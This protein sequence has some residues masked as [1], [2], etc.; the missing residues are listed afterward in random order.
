MTTSANSVVILDF[1]TSGLS[2]DMGDRAIEVGAVRLE[3]GVVKARFQ[4]LMNPGRRIQPFIEQLTGITNAMLQDAPPCKDVMPR[5]ADF[6]GDSNLVA[7]NASFDRR[8]LDAELSYIGRSY[9]GSFACSV[10]A[11]RRIY[12]DA[13]SH[14]LG[15][16]LKYLE[17]PTGEGFHR[18]LYDAE[19]TAKLWCRLLD[20]MSERFNLVD[21]PFT[22]MQKLE[23]TAK[24]SVPNMLAKWTQ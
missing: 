7:H 1:E 5:F 9:S 24:K 12:T 20:D 2:P 3:N 17:I 11:S 10:L 22:L 8:F 16:I 15:E 14:K 13:P 21:P 19:M 6:I 4:E 18:A 23:K